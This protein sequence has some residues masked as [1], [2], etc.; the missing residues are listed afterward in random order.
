[1]LVCTGSGTGKET[2][3]E[4]VKQFKSALGDFPVIVGAGVTSVLR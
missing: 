4:K 3:V 1:M 2:P